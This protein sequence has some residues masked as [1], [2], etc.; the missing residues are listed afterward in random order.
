MKRAVKDWPNF[1]VV[2]VRSFHL[3]F[4]FGGC[5]RFEPTCSH[6]CA[7]VLREKGLFFGFWLSLKRILKCHPMGPSGY[8]SVSE[9]L[10]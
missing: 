10:G 5:C 7:E 9:R 2:V 6:Y 1:I 4:S 8:D 3:F